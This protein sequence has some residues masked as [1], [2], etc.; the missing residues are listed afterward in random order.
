MWSWIVS[1]FALSCTKLEMILIKVKN[2]RKIVQVGQLYR[3][4]GETTVKTGRRIPLRLGLSNNPL[5]EPY[6]TIC[7]TTNSGNMTNYIY[8]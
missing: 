1:W 7:Q 6:Y 4:K 8:W 5:V 2:I 3:Q